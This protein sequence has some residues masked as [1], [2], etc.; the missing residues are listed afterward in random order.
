MKKALTLYSEYLFYDI[1]KNKIF[2]I[3]PIVC[4]EGHNVI[5]IKINNKVH[6]ISEFEK[7][8]SY[9]TYIGEL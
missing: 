4:C 3:E 2:E 8:S 1:K 5:L 7:K 6:T 9:F